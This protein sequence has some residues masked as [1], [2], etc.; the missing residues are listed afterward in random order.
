MTI[1]LR[2]IAED[3]HTVTVSRDAWERV[4]SALED[5]EDAAAVGASLA[6]EAELGPAEFR[7]LAYTAGEARRIALD[8][9][10]PVTIWRGRAGMTQRQLAAAALT[11]PSYPAEIEAGK[12][13]GSAAALAR[14]AWALRVPMEHLVG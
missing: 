14:I 11:S 13:P 6:A 7:R 4:V 1:T 3:A 8:D 9:A 5:Q 10:S 12:K 2:P